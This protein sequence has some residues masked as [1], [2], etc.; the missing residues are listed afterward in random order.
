MC[1]PSDAVAV[2]SSY[3]GEGTGPIFL[4][5]VGCS[6]ENETILVECFRPNDPGV[7]NCE[8]SEDAGVFCS[9]KRWG[10]GVGG[11]WYYVCNNTAVPSQSCY[12]G[13]LRL[14]DGSTD[15]EGRLEICVDGSWSTVCDN[16]WSQ[17]DAAV[18]CRQLGFAA[19][20]KPV[21]TETTQP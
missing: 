19:T 11:G 13:E 20:G 18:A 17:D 7:S 14:V 6:L 4:D 15:L 3:F 12:N 16:L 9:S 8:H 21:C 10:G 1:L 2:Y 5:D